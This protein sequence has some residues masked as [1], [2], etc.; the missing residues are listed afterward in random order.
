MKRQSRK[1][2]LR[3]L[4]CQVEPLAYWS[5]ARA[6]ATL[7]WS[8]NDCRCSAALACRRVCRKRQASFAKIGPDSS[9]PMSGGPLFGTVNFSLRYRQ[10]F[11]VLVQSD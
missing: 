10:A 11:L 2:I 5:M 9:V 3:P 8:G 1:R 4:N 7:P 6:R